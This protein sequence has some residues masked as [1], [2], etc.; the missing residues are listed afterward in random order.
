MYYSLL[1]SLRRLTQFTSTIMVFMEIVYQLASSIVSFQLL[2]KLHNTQFFHCRF[3]ISK[4]SNL[5]ENIKLLLNEMY[6]L[7]ASTP[8]K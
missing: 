2:F 1:I 3:E 4:K 8:V 5:K 7:N 6:V